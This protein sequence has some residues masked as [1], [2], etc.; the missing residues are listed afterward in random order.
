MKWEKTDSC[1][2]KPP[3]FGVICHGSPRT[4]IHDPK[5]EIRLTHDQHQHG[6]GLGVN[7]AVAA[8]GGAHV[9]S[10]WGRPLPTSL[11]APIT[12]PLALGGPLRKRR[13]EEAG[14]TPQ[15][16]CLS[17]DTQ[18]C[19]PEA[20]K[21]QPPPCLSSHQPHFL[22]SSPRFLESLPEP[23]PRLRACFGDQA[24]RAL[25]PVPRLPRHLLSTY[26]IP[27]IA[28]PA[29]AGGS[30]PQPGSCLAPG[31]EAPCGDFEA[32]RGGN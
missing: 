16:P 27:G 31:S 22:A 13:E 12:L 20:P 28:G 11:L 25:T 29:H 32:S 10:L 21:R 5:N 17:G 7:G 26:C 23:N 4:R 1:C 30:W 18:G 19:L 3:Q 2:F 6:C 14:H 15:L 9:P 24:Q 8:G